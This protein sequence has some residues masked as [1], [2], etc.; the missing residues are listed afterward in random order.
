MKANPCN[1]RL[2]RGC[3]AVTLAAALTLVAACSDRPTPT[4]TPAPAPPPAPRPLPTP[5]VDWRQAPITPGDWSWSMVAGRS[6]ASFAGGQLVLR[7]DGAGGTITMLR[8]G[9]AEGRVPMTVQTSN[10]TRPLSGTAQGG[11]MPGLAVTLPVRDPLW[12]AMAF[13]RGRFAVET[14]GLPTLYVPSWPEVSR[15]IEDCR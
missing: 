9:S 2:L 5:S 15:V 1:F 10:L 6:V 3:A 12:D 4:P 7:C 8:A 11:S 13:S 14:L